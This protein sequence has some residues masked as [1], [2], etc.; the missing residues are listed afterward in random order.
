MM[1]WFKICAKS[2]KRNEEFLQKSLSK[3]EEKFEKQRIESEKIHQKE[4]QDLKEKFEHQEIR[5]EIIH[6]KDMQDIKNMM[7]NELKAFRNI[8]KLANFISLFRLNIK[9]HFNKNGKNYLYWDQMKKE[10]DN[11]SINEAVISLGMKLDSWLILKNLS[12]DLNSLKHDPIRIEDALKYIQS[13]GNTDYEEYPEPFY[14]LIEL[15]KST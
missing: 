4:K 14:D 13:L 9:D 10:E 11:D 12:H 8:H 1:Y 3:I 7:N 2:F 6:Q 5:N 15:F